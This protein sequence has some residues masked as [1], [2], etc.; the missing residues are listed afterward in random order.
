MHIPPTERVLPSAELPG[1]G[2][3]HSLQPPAAHLGP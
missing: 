2:L 1:T 3:G